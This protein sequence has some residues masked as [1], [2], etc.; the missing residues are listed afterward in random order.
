MTAVYLPPDANAN[1]AIGLLHANISNMQIMDPATVQIIEKVY[2]NIKLGY[3]ARPL[4][5]LGQSDPLSL[6]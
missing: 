2:T 6:F 5:H 3:R 4:Q 1:S